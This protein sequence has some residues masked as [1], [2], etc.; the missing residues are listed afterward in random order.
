MIDALLTGRLA[1]D[2]KAGT[3]KTGNAYATARVLVP[4]GDDR[5]TVSV[6]A[7]DA[8]CVA[9]LLALTA[10]DAVALAGELILKTWT[11]KDGTTH[12]AADMKAHA[13]LT[14]YHVT[15][16]R[17]AMQGASDE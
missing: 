12:P 6:I 2:P 1:V 5:A 3:T 4:S 10:G 8:G 17:K 16:K 15:R 13:V 11:G 9:A 7:F 14:P